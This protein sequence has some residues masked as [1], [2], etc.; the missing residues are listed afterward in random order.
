MGAREWSLLGLLALLWGCSFLF[1][2]IALRDI[3]VFTLALGRTGLG[4][5]ALAAWLMLRGTSLKPIAQR[6]GGFILLGALRGAIPICLIVWAQTRID[7]GLAGILNSTSPLFTMIV[8][9]Y[10]AN[11]RLTRRKLIGCAVGMSG[12]VLMIGVDALHGLGDSVLGQLAMTGATCCYGFAASYGKRFEGMP[13]ALSAAGMLAGASALILP[14]SLLLEHPWTLRPG[15]I[16]LAALFGLAILSTAIGFVVWFRL[17]QTAGPSNTSLVTFLIPLVALGLGIAIL[18][19]QPTGTSLAG[20]AIL[21]AGLTI[22]QMTRAQETLSLR[23]A[24]VVD[25]EFAYATTRDTMREYT[26]ATWGKWSEED[27]RRRTNENIAAGTTSIILLGDRPIGI[28]VV[29][30]KADCIRLAQLYILP[31]YQ[32]RGFGSELIERLLA[33]ARIAGLPLR[34]RVLRVN[35][36]FHL[37][38]RLGFKVVEATPERYFMEHTT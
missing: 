26:V 9:H 1:I 13:H 27:V 14:L 28:R 35:P 29:E 6:W 23:P 18:G 12:V 38:Q 7:S 36:A 31:A 30:S 19:E 3:P 37:Y 17:I 8:A 24:T 16:P 22:T 33:E 20:V 11:E 32:R 4:A 25:R 5:A 21:F 34:L 2:E 10:L 15:A